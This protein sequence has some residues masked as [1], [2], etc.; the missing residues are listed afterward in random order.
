[1]I[2]FPDINFNRVYYVAAILVCAWI[3]LEIRLFTVQILN[4]DFYV[5][6]SQ[7]QSAKK[8]QL[9]ARR[10]M[11]FDRNGACLATNLIHY[12]FGVDL[13]RL[14]NREKVARNFALIFDKPKSFYLKKMN[15]DKDFVFLERKVT[16]NL[17]ARIDKIEDPGLVK[18]EGSRRYYPF[19]RCAAQVIGFT[20]VDDRGVNGLELQYQDQLAGKNGWTYLTADARRIFMQN[21]DLPNEEP[22]P[23][24]DLHLTLDKDFQ[25]IV[26]QELDRGV[27]K[28]NA[29]SGIAVLMNPNSGEILAMHSSPG[30]DPND[31]ARFTSEH[32]KNRAILDIFEPGSTFKVFPA[33]A[34]LQEGLKKPDDL[35][36][37]ENGNYRIY[38]HNINDHEKY[39]WLSFRKVIQNSSN[40]GMAKLTIDLPKNKFYKYLKNF[41]FDSP[42]GIDL[43]GEAR[44]MLTK[45][46]QFSGLSKAVIS[47]GQEV[48]VTAIQIVTAYAAVV[49]GGDLPRPIVVQK[50]VDEE[51][52]VRMENESQ[53]IRQVLDQRIGQILK[54]FMRDAVVNGTGQKA[55]I[56]GIQVGG[57]TGTAQKYDRQTNRYIHNAY[58]ASFI[59]FVPYEKPEFVLGIFIDE[60]KQKYYGGDVAA[61][62]FAAIMSRILGL[63][64]QENFEPEAEINITR[65]QQPLPDLKGF[66][67]TAIEEYLEIK[68]VNYSVQG[69]GTHVLSQSHKDDKVRITLG[70]PEIKEKIVPN[71]RGMTIRE[72]L[73][74][75]DFSKIHLR[76]VGNGKIIEQSIRPGTVL[77]NDCELVLTCSR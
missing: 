25:T 44:G 63:A 21:V 62:V 52:E 22:E 30:Y 64:P 70:T 77:L 55:V 31:P 49:N 5:E 60:P 35:V 14:E 18:M 47:F 26:E 50:I 13:S 39:G 61:P 16:E 29:R 40:I 7:R 33:A 24:V 8:I 1:M 9:I 34:L 6:Q 73:K 72:A 43:D 53:I 36:Y 20:D 10:G 54:E 69:E 48:G 76:I 66:P 32:R 15:S 11:I 17:A 2:Q 56:P 41:G 38:R 4:H 71:L 46:E 19:G 59:G 12:D 68:D 58:L 28:F 23:G 65:V 27:Q 74:R 45:P 57:K 37:C 67:F 3:L 42:T 75:I 51:E